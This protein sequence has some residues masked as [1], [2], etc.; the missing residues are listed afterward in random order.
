MSLQ[1]F[2]LLALIAG[3]S[4]TVLYLRFSRRYYSFGPVVRR[5]AWQSPC[6]LEETASALERATSQGRVRGRRFGSRILLRYQEWWSGVLPRLALDLQEDEL[7]VRM[8]CTTR[9]FLGTVWLGVALLLLL[10]DGGYW[11]LSVLLVVGMVFLHRAQWR[12]D[13]VRLARLLP[14]RAALRTIGVL[15]C[16]RC[17]YDL[18]GR[19]ERSPCPECGYLANRDTKVLRI[20]TIRHCL[21]E[22]ARRR[23]T[24]S[25]AGIV[26]GI[27][28]LGLGPILLAMP[29]WF[30]ICRLTSQSY[31]FWVF[32]LG[33][34][35][36]T[37]PLLFRM[38]LYYGGQYMNEAFSRIEV[39]FG[40]YV[41]FAQSHGE[42]R[43]RLF[44][45]LVALVVELLLLGPCL[46]LRGARQLRLGRELDLVDRAVVAETVLALG[47]RGRGV[48]PAELLKP[49][50]T[51]AKL[52]PVLA[53][54]SYHGWI[55]VSENADRVFLYT[56]AREALLESS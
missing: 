35:V 4:E 42:A 17:G 10:A 9:P 32:Y 15:I 37:I 55:G 8:E 51:M 27:I 3:V 7:G 53:W 5:E 11:L 47:A 31:P 49:G 48:D 33:M 43:L 44:G 18:H 28:L 50:E 54:L 13:G 40:D 25:F 29:L 2:Y 23:S 16:A 56:E 21:D 24:L 20:E 14:L 22:R 52:A 6:G 39:K 46:V 41:P 45:G 12:R 1:P 38:E 30:V 36:V 19:N 26:V 34:A